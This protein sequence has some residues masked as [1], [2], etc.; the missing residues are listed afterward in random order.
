MT[1]YQKADFLITIDYARKHRTYMYTGC[2]IINL[3][4]DTWGYIFPGDTKVTVVSENAIIDYGYIELNN[5]TV[6]SH[7]CI[8]DI[9]KVSN[10]K[11][12]C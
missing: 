6:N 5:L 2:I 3:D 4:Y 8:Y 1:N 12:D 10:K 9:E 7:R 11:E